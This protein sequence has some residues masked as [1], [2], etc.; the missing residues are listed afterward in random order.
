[1]LYFNYTVQFNLYVIVLHN[2]RKF[3]NTINVVRSASSGTAGINAT[4]ENPRLKI[5]IFDIANNLNLE[6][7]T[8]AP[9]R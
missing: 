5:V 8:V 1:M 4:R 9:T 6:S 7:N 3:S 2:Y